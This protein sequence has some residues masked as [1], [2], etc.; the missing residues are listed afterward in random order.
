MSDRIANL[1]VRHKQDQTLYYHAANDDRQHDANR[2]DDA[3][4]LQRFHDPLADV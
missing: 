3:D 4:A 1:S 2:W